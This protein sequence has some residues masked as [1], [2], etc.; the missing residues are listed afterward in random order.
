MGLAYDG[1][2][3]F[4][5]LPVRLIQALGFCASAL[6]ISVGLFYAIWYFVQTERFPNG[7][8]T[9]IASVWLL[10]GLQLA[11]VVDQG[12]SQSPDSFI[13]HA[14]TSLM[15]AWN[16]VEVPITYAAPSNSVGSASITESLRELWRLRSDGG[17]PQPE[18]RQ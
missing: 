4:S 15:H 18:Q 2:F 16:W 7:F 11:T 3:S 8:A 17:A 14:L 1:L 10:A 6:A 13:T 5:E 12:L 9:V